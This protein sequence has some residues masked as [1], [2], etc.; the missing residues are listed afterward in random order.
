MANA[1]HSKEKYEQIAL[2]LR[3]RKR[4]QETKDKI[5]KALMGHKFSEETLNKMRKPRSE[6]ARNNMSKS[7]KGRIPWN[8]GRT[9][10]YSKDTIEKLRK[11]NLGKSISF[12][13]KKKLRASMIKF[14]QLQNP[15]Y[16]PP[17]YLEGEVRRNN[18]SIRRERL[19]KNGGSHTKLQWKHLKSA[20]EFRCII[21]KRQEPEIK[22]T[23]D[24][25]IAVRHGGSDNIENIQPLCQSCN[26]KKR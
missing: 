24:H 21:C 17:S 23:K 13:T 18:E 26:S 20:Y 14:F 15:N 8:K 25:I 19:S 9:G 7:M 1:K 11:A 10:V 6:E 12:E 2:K 22:L 16:E 5:S 3:G 4:S